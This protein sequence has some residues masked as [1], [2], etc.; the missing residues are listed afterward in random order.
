MT[1]AK[2]EANKRRKIQRIWVNNTSE[3]DILNVILNLRAKS[4]RYNRYDQVLQLDNIFNA[5]FFQILCCKLLAIPECA[6]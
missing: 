3:A 2:Y 6:K 4:H 5:D 1:S